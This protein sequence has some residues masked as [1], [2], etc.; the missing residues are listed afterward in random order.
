MKRLIAFF[1]VGPFVLIAAIVGVRTAMVSST[2]LPRVAPVREALDENAAAQHLA[3]AIRFA[4][5]SDSP[6]KGAGAFEGLIDYLD[7]NYP[8]VHSG[9]RREPI[10]LHSLLYTWQGSEPALPGI[11]FLAHM[12]VV[13]VDSGS[14]S[15]W[16]HG[17]YSGDVADGFI[18]G[19]GTLDMKA[20][21]LGLLE[22]VEQLLREGKQPR[23][24][25]YL[26]FG[27]DEEV[28]GDHG[29]G[30]IAALLR[31]RGI[32]VAYSL[33]EG[34]Y[35]V[36]GVVPGV[37]SPVALIGISE[38]GYLTL[39]LSTSAAGGHSSMPSR[40]EAIARLSRAI[41]RLEE[42]QMP[43][44]LGG[45]VSPML[46]ALAPVVPY[47]QRVAFAN[48]WLFAPLL[49]NVL[50]SAPATNALVRTTV[51][52][53]VIR[54]GIK[55]NILP[56]S[57]EAMVNFRIRPGDTIASVIAHVRAVIDDQAVA[58]ATIG[59]S[60]DPLPLSSI[61]SDGYR[62]LRAAAETIYPDAVVVP[63]LVVAGTDTHHYA[64]I[65]FNSYRFEPVR[66]EASD[67]DRIHGNNER[68][69]VRD[70]ADMIRFYS[71]TMRET[72]F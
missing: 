6:D 39:R 14:E 28:G 35:V 69:A 47:W 51:A 66:L 10:G 55:D 57:A 50:E 8:A 61:D 72:A 41:Q 38:K 53:T 11:M 46:D 58:I 4:T 56:Q 15:S 45:A 21:V 18:W 62:A 34:G 67:L 9:L 43:A 31:S 59:A 7:R 37:S 60:N 3:G 63:T 23:R 32:R 25:I 44:S 24:T 19:R 71:L 54:G 52:P 36:H 13:P 48:R 49:R 26:A 42:R 30:A 22:S 1:V 12:D 16:T 33:D 2:N 64:A 27:G 65:T 20:P 29:A 17:P 40:D 68:I 70:F 5:V